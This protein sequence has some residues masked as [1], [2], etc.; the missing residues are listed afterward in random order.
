MVM[1][2]SMI[3]GTIGS[4][5]NLR[6]DKDS[7]LLYRIESFCFV[8][9]GL[10]EME[11]SEYHSNNEEVRS[12]FILRKALSESS[13]QQELEESLEQNSCLLDYDD[14]K[15]KEIIEM[16]KGS[17]EERNAGDSGM[18]KKIK[19]KYQVESK[20]DAGLYSL[21]FAQCP[22]STGGSSGRGDITA[23]AISYKL[24]AKFQNPGPRYLSACDSKLPQVF[25]FFFVCY[26]LLCFGW[27]YLLFSAIC[28]HLTNAQTK[29]SRNNNIRVHTIHWFMGIL[30]IFKIMAM[31][32]Q[33][34]RYFYID[35]TGQGEGWEFVYYVFASLKGIS[36]FI[37]ILLI[38]T[39]WS[40]VK[41]YLNS[42]EKQIIAIVLCLQI[43]DNIALIFFDQTAPG[44]QSWLTW[45]DILHIVD[46]LC[47]AAVLFPI[48]WSIRHLRQASQLSDDGT[49]K[50]LHNIQKLTLF[51]QFYI[52]VVSYIYF[53]RIIVFLLA[54]TLPFDKLWLRYIFSEFATFTFYLITGIKFRPRE[55]NPYL[56]LKRSNPDDDDSLNTPNLDKGGG[57]DQGKDNQQFEKQHNFLPP[58]SSSDNFLDAEYGVGST[59]S[60]S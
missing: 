44:S 54:A 1:V 57:D 18:N 50:N 11:I 32:S 41:P 24:M 15:T 7:R 34:M 13:A 60:S 51:R 53:T 59:S 40:L 30:L 38:G 17:N 6:I 2:G 47:C 29:M 42:K 23:T 26:L 46:I 28:S 33:S 36:L 12:G 55:H 52:L 9:G 20:H 56:P 8:N 5:H 22:S 10:V 25:A 37:V 27:F 45:R 39:G 48:I 31:L 35:K 21:I 19:K 58:S 49:T 3:S 14:K 43:I 16:R 4:V